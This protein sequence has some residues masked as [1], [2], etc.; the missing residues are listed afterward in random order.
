MNLKHNILALVVGKSNEKKPSF[1]SQGTKDKAQNYLVTLKE[2]RNK[3]AG[4][5]IPF[6]YEGKS[7]GP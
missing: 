2:P 1:T 6:L 7:P 4:K 3:D 5:K